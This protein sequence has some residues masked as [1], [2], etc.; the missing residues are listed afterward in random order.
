MT[1]P[2]PDATAVRLAVLGLPSAGKTSYL[3]AVY[4][5]LDSGGPDADR[6]A[7][8]PGDRAYLEQ[9]RDAWLAGRPVDR[10]AVGTGENI[11]LDAVL[12]GMPVVLH[13]PDVSGESFTHAL[14]SR[15]IDTALARAVQNA[16]GLLLF[17]HPSHQRPRVSIHSA[18]R[19]GLV[20]PN[21][22]LAATAP[23]DPAT[24]PAETQLVD[25]LQ[26]AARLGRAAPL[27]AAV[28]ISAWDR[29]TDIAPGN[30]IQQMP[31]LRQYLDNTDDPISTC[32]YGAS[33]QGGTYGADDDPVSTPPASRSYIVLEDGTRHDDIVS[34]LRWAAG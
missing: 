9:I 30:W 12:D 3:A 21:R 14:A 18:R 31:L 32:I 34:P 15:S 24:V 4:H 33:A 8:Q 23:F 6:L 2:E 27:R 22:P 29:M 5:A 10:T 19:A 17:T 20:D 26:W 25:L 11:E 1:A 13:I 7:R 28:V 16:Q